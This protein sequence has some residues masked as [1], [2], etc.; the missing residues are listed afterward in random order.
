MTWRVELGDKP[1]HLLAEI[2]QARQV[3]KR[4]TKPMQAA[5][6]KAYPDDPIVCAWKTRDALT[7]H[8]FAAWDNQAQDWLLTPAGREVY[9]WAGKP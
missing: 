6:A 4:L 9:R 1:I 8:G 2:I 5:V 7:L 3:W